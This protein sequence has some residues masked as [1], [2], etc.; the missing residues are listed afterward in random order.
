[1]IVA[2][3]IYLN[4]FGQNQKVVEVYARSLCK[5]FRRTHDIHRYPSEVV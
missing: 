2:F 5:R 3:G 4:A 1:V